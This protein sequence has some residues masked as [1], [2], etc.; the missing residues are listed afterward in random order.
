MN[1]QAACRTC[2]Y[3][4]PDYV[5]EGDAGSEPSHGGT[6]RFNPP[7]LVQRPAGDLFSLWPTVDQDEWCGQWHAAHGRQLPTVERFELHH[8]A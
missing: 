1:P 5:I 7:Q 2:R 8:S 6:C 3:W 4:A